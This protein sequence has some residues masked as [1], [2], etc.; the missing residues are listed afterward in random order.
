MVDLCHV[1]D[2]GVPPLAEE[3]QK[4]EQCGRKGAREERK[5]TREIKRKKIKEEN[6]IAYNR[7]SYYY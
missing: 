7:W 3:Q 6:D 5:R 1:A 4:V 2:R